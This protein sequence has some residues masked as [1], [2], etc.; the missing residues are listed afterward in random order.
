MFEECLKGWLLTG[1][2]L[3][4]VTGN[5]TKESASQMVH[6]AASL[7]KLGPLNLDQLP[8]VQTIKLESGISHLLQVPLADPK[9]ENSCTLTHYVVGPADGMKMKLVNK[10]V[11]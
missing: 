4:Y 9:N 6:K 11:M 8:L 5:F 1:R 3:W 7:F 2:Y 10:I